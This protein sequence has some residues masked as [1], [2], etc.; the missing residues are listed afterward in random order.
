[1][2]RVGLA[3]GTLLVLIGLL[4]AAPLALA[5]WTSVSAKAAITDVFLQRV[6][7]DQA[8]LLVDF[9][10]TVDGGSERTVWCSLAG[11]QADARLRPVD[12][13]VMP[14]AAAQAQA[15]ALLGEDSRWRRDLRGVL[16][17]PGHPESAVMV[18]ARRWSGRPRL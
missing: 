15:R 7:A 9:E 18:S 2:R 1:M 11:N 4:V 13:V 3:A 14:L 16:T 17:P 5:R 8:R 10:F 12:D 6:G